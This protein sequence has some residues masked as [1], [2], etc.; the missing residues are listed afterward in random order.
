MESLLETLGRHY[1]DEPQPMTLERTRLHEELRRDFRKIIFHTAKKQTRDTLDKCDPRMLVTIAEDALLSIWDRYNPEEGSLEDFMR[2]QIRALM[3][4]YLFKFG[5]D[6][7]RRRQVLFKMQKEREKFVRE[8][9][10]EP[11][12]EELSDLT[13]IPVKYLN[14]YSGNN[15]P[16]H[17]ELIQEDSVFGQSQMSPDDILEKQEIVAQAHDILENQGLKP[18][19]STLLRRHFGIDCEA[20]GDKEYARKIG[21]TRQAVGQRRAVILKKLKATLAC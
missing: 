14:L 5:Y 19:E 3:Q 20:I 12:M 17:D 21:R 9:A 16:Y 6:S 1:H 4:G 8:N 11:T 10:Y 15:Q 13:G 7:S 18:E 2:V